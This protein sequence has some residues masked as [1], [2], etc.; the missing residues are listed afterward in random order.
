MNS[1]RFLISILSIIVISIY[2]SGC[3]SSTKVT[4]FWKEYPDKSFDFEK[5]GIIGISKNATV[6]KAVENHID[7]LLTEQG[8][9]TVGGFAFL[10][11][12]ATEENLTIEVLLKL[13]ETE[14]VDAVLTVSLLRTQD[15]K[16]YVSGSYYYYPWTE[17]P[18]NDYYGQMSNYLYSPGYTIESRSYFLESNLYTFPEGELIWSAQTKSTNV[19]E[20]NEGAGEVAR[21]IVRNLI[22]SKTIMPLREQE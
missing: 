19:T 16:Q 1:A 17:V 18:F 12:Q 21:A 2:L 13:L 10:P 20:L 11:P 15:S 6:R 3:G 8:F 9:N 4:G 7:V 14:K 5:I 22:T